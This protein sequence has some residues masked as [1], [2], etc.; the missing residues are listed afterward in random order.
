MSGGG[1]HV[2][3]VAKAQ[4]F[5]TGG[6]SGGY[7]LSSIT[8]NVD[9]H[10]TF[11]DVLQA[12]LWSAAG[13]GGPGSKVV[14]LIAPQIPS[15][16]NTAPGALVFAAPAN[17]RLSAGTTYYVV[18]Y[19]ASSDNSVVPFSHTASDSE[20]AGAATGWSIEDNLW[21]S[22]ARHPATWSENLYDRAFRIAVNTAAAATVEVPV[23][24]SA[25]PQSSTTFAIEVLT[26]GDHPAT[27]DTDYTIPASVTFGPGDNMSKNV[28]LAITDDALV[29]FDETIMLRIAAADDPVN[30]LGDH[31]TRHTNG[32]QATV[33]I[34]DDEAP[35]ARV[36]FGDDGGRAAVYT[37]A[38]AESVDPT[39][40]VSVTALPSV[41]TTFV[42]EVSG[43]TATEGSG[44][45]F[46][47]A[48]KAV[49]FGPSDTTRTKNLSIDFNDDSLVEDDQTIM[50]R[51]AAAGDPATTVEDLYGRH[52]NGSQATV[53]I[54]DDEADEAKVAFGANAAATAK[55][56]RTPGEESGS[57]SVPITISAAPEQDTAFT[58][59]VSGTATQDSDYTI[60]AET[61]T[62][63]KT[64]G[65]TQ[66]LQVTLTN[67]M[68]VEDDQTIELE[69][70]SGTGF[71]SKYQ[72]DA[73]GKL[74]VVTIDDD[75]SETA[76]IA[77]G[78]SAASTDGHTAAV[79][80]TVTGGDLS[81]PVTI[82]HLP[83]S[84]VTIAVEVLDA[85]TARDADDANNA[86]GN[87]KDYT[88]ATK[89]VTFEP[90]GDKTQNLTVSIAD[91]DVEEDPETIELSIAAADTTVDDLGD[92]YLR[93]A[94]G[95]TSEVTI[96]SE[97]AVSEV[98]L[99]MTLARQPGGDRAYLAS[100]GTQATVTA[101]SD[102]PVGPGGWVVT[103]SSPLRY[104]M[105]QGPICAANGGRG[106]LDGWACPNDFRLPPAFTIEEGQ[107][108]ATAKL[109]IVSDT[110][111]EVNEER[112][113]LTASAARG[114]R[115]LST[116]RLSLRLRD[117]G[118]GLSIDVGDS[119]L[120]L[121]PGEAGAYRVS[122]RSQPSANVVITPT[123]G[124]TDTA[125][126]SGALTFTDTNWQTP[127]EVTVTAVAAGAVTVTHTVAST[128][129]VYGSLASP[130]S[131]AVK[132][133]APV[134][135]YRIEPSGSGA[136]GDTVEL[137][138][139]LGALAPAGG[140]EFTVDRS[141]N[142]AR[143]YTISPAPSQGPEA[144]LAD[145]A[146]DLAAPAATVTVAVGE[147]RVTLSE[148]LADDDLIE[149]DEHYYVEISTTAA[150]W[151]AETRT[152]NDRT[153]RYCR[154]D[155]ACARVTIADT[156]AATA[157]IAFGDSTADGAAAHTA[158][159]GEGGASIDVAVTVSAL[160]HT[161][162]SFD[163]TVTG[164]TATEGDDYTI[165]TKTVT[166]GGTPTTDTATTKN[167]AITITDDTVSEG[168]ETIELRIAAAADPP[169][170]LAD[171]YQRH[172][173]ASTATIT[174]TDNDGAVVL[175][176]AGVTLRPGASGDYT[177]KLGTRPATDVTVTP[178][179]DD[180]DKATVSGALTFTSANWDQPQTVTVTGVADGTA[181]IS[182]TVSGA[183]PSYP[184][185]LTVADVD[186]TVAA[187][188][189]ATL[190]VAPNP[191]REGQSV[192]VTVTLSEAAGTTKTLPIVLGAA[193]DTAETGDHATL[194]NIAVT[195]TGT[196]FRA[197]IGTNHD[198]D[199]KDETFTV[200]LGDLTALG[201]LSAGSPNSAQ[202]TITD[203][204][205]PQALRLTVRPANN[206]L[207]LTWT[208][209]TGDEITGYTVE[210]KTSDAPDTAA[211]TPED[212]ATG[213]VTVPHTS[214]A[215]TAT[216]TG[217]D[218][219]TT[220]NVRI[221][222][223]G[224]PDITGAVTASG[225]PR[226]RQ[227]T[228]PTGD[229]PTGGG[230][231]GPTGGGPTD[232]DTEPDTADFADVDTDNIHA[233]NIA[234]IHK[235]GITTGCATR[236]QLRY[237]P[238]QPVTRAQ[239]A[240]FLTRALKLDTAGDPPQFADVNTNNIH[241]ANIAAIH[242]A[243]ITTGCSQTGTQTSYCPNQP[244]TRAQMATFLTRALKLD[245]PTDPVE[246]A[247]VNTNSVHAAA[248]AAIHKAGITAGCAT[249]PLRFCPNQPV[250]RAEMATFLTRALKL[251]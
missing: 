48:T 29:E 161:A 118:A 152:R 183:D 33:T 35:A 159:V 224:T 43:G 227:P 182:H 130:G 77:F 71:F 42:I 244:V 57:L 197:T 193:G 86:T 153:E 80:E 136:E 113:V 170:G 141:R 76:K 189:T 107:T 181:T 127:Q 81:V 138:I 115:E 149:P 88:I 122:L 198:D 1:E 60:A 228:R 251:E 7:V 26:A 45:D 134:K 175:S 123:S 162:T 169:V 220:Y 92:Y 32:S 82:N 233:A 229:S 241:A 155:A 150:G 2:N 246:F 212:P 14:S 126:V 195:A 145:A 188:T 41:S 13:A 194:A 216:I 37:A 191:V 110:R 200:A 96:T 203:D 12:E 114:T 52:A 165:A 3:V 156:D 243:G 78:T 124:D 100:E 65:L 89:S 93:H 8:L 171:R 179:S 94:D 167:I 46:R 125:T 209:P 6:T 201:S 5:T 237:C 202:V 173:A 148:V 178:T 164:G 19:A 213:W 72:R 73:L 144:N 249:T 133:A 24:I 53:T 40:A 117:S 120:E 44:D 64:S 154:E 58:V 140:L 142:H 222:P 95:A 97:D 163:V 36:A 242:K 248:I 239:M 211:T 90:G 54:E 105:T 25:L 119:G 192:T 49:T 68:L 79:A 28:T 137:E 247:D 217:L 9:A 102:I 104:P 47:I 218:N 168:D 50:L 157:R 75:E 62:F 70:A 174:I 226:Q 98:V 56:T 30:D 245:T 204:D 31:Y 199:T 207:N 238:N 84:S 17:T 180:T 39:V 85:S 4:G 74:A 176:T 208:L 131:V 15:V 236:P 210:Y 111:T 147:R 231:G 219:G 34:A 225:T 108:A 103:A 83:E 128:D 132:V 51:V 234:A 69:I 20:D 91:D 215:R 158:S 112:M 206:A 59:A 205:P 101:T 87:P 172:P 61:F 10:Y 27:K 185:D 129:S 221:T 109:T 66:N 166:F 160:P 214:T 240:T 187:T 235:A 55:L 250:T 99:S 230:P 232:T 38:H 67:D 16:S 186:V 106:Q 23:T 63:T 22:S 116:N 121:L 190:S 21:E 146:A 11:F 151:N 139:T 184:A 143:R 223:Q 177:I 18:L 196:V 135:E